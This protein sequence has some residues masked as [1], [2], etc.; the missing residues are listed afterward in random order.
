MKIAKD[1]EEKVEV[2][3]KELININVRIVYENI[4]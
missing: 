3:T 2:K 4:L 1:L